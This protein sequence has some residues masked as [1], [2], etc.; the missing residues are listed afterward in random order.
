M[1]ASVSAAVASTAS[2]YAAAPT[3]VGA[4][5]IGITTDGTAA[6]VTFPAKTVG[7]ELPMICD[8]LVGGSDPS[9][10]FQ[11]D[12]SQFLGVRFKT[13][14]DGQVPAGI[15]LVIRREFYAALKDRSREWL[16]DGVAVSAAPGEWMINLVPLARE[17]GWSTYYDFTYVR[18]KEAESW[19]EDL[20]DVTMMVLRITP[21][22]D[23]A[24]AYSVDQFQLMGVDGPTEPAQLTSLQAY[25]GVNTVD[26]LT[27]AQRAQ[28]RDGDGMS[29]LNEILAG[30][31]PEDASSVLAAKCRKVAGGNEVMWD[32]VLGATYGVM[33][34]TD[35]GGGFEL[36]ASGIGATSTAPMTY[37]DTAPVAGKPNFYKVVKY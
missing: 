2:N 26:E 30:M 31:D 21:A 8:L 4:S 7:N 16:H 32:G 29:D 1:L 25:F 34:S 35:L 6:T 20:G 24:Q 9:S 12:L 5:K 13:T 22:G 36:I 23:G 18:K 15:Q 37:T 27:A 14:G 11:G 17:K 3:S 33:R 19:A 28:D 10:Q